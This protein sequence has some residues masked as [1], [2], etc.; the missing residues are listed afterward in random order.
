VQILLSNYRIPQ[1]LLGPR[2]GPDLIHVPN[3]FDVGLLKRRS[4]AYDAYAGY[5]LRVTHLARGVRYLVE[6]YRISAHD[7]LS[8]VERTRQSGDTITLRAALPTP[9]I[10]LIVIRRAADGH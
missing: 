3:V 9:A 7:D 2:A 6:R 4:V 10:E 5:E 8:L 1:E